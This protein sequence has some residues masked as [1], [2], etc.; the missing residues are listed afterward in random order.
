MHFCYLLYILL[1]V[2]E[3][4]SYFD[5]SDELNEQTIHS[6]VAHGLV[7]VPAKHFIQIPTQITIAK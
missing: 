3:T 1:F 6:Y 5:I 2:F 7:S 4:S